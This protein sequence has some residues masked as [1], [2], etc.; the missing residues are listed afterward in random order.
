MTAWKPFLGSSSGT[1]THQQ[2]MPTSNTNTIRLHRVLRATPE[3]VY[4]AFLDAEA[5]AKWL[6]PNGF[7]GQVHHLEAKA[8]AHPPYQQIRRPEPP[9]RNANDDHLAAGILRN[10]VEHH[11]GRDTRRHPGRSLLSRLAG[12]ADAAG[13]T[14]RDRNSG[15]TVKRSCPGVSPC[16]CAWILAIRARC[17]RFD[18]NPAQMHGLT[19]NSAGLMPTSGGP[20]VVQGNAVSTT[21][22]GQSIERTWLPPQKDR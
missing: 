9:W 8:P 5:F 19:P 18:F 1:A 3:R 14:G 20:F 21:I 4:R 11:A 10:R 2:I 15:S 6:P 7:T 17:L 16:I 13:E 22:T 12:I